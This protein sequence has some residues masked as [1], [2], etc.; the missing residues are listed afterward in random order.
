MS[1]SVELVLLQCGQCGTPLP[2][3]EDEVA[4]LCPTCGQGWQL[5]ADQLRP[6]TVCWQGVR[7]GTAVARWLPFWVFH[8]KVNFQQREAFSGRSGPD[9]L[10]RDTCRF[11]VPAYPC[12]LGQIER[13]GG[14]LTRRQVPLAAGEPAGALRA[15]TLLPDDAR[16]AVDF[17]VLTIE[18]D[19]RDKLRTVLFSLDLGAP[20]LWMLPFAGEPEVK[21]LIR[22]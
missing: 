15:C 6:L 9:D 20:E 16:R 2:A 3:E 5:G 18:A 10:W 17:I 7:P 21:T 1:Q 11:F 13:L 12:D 22:G 19:R 8:G 4:W 14:E